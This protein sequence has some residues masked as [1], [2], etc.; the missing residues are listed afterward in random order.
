MIVDLIIK[1]FLMKDW[2]LSKNITFLIGTGEG[3]G[4]SIFIMFAG[5]ILSLGAVL[6]SQKREIKELEQTYVLETF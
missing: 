4:A 5:V 6:F 3:R 1:P 2:I